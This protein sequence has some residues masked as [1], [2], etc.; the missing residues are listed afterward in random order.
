MTYGQNRARCKKEHKTIN[1]LIKLFKYYYFELGKHEHEM[2]T[3]INLKVINLFWY[4]EI[5]E[6]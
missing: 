4:I 3:V 6:E 2:F 5:Y 1:R